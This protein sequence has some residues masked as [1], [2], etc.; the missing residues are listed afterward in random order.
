[1]EDDSEVASQGSYDES[2]H[3]EDSKLLSS[4]DKTE[5]NPILNK[6]SD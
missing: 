1:M 4:E 5:Q 3:S 2:C 6:D